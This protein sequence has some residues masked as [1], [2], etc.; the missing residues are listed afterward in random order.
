MDIRQSV[1]ETMRQN[2]YV[3]LCHRLT[4]CVCLA[5]DNLMRCYPDI[6]AECEFI[7]S[8]VYLESEASWNDA[9]NCQPIDEWEQ[10]QYWIVGK[11]IDNGAWEF[12]GLFS[13]RALA[14]KACRNKSYFIA[15]AT[16]DEAIVDTSEPWDGLVYPL[17]E[18]GI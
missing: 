11:Y 12:Q 10:A 4:K 18:E 9:Q 1:L 13:S 2:G 6:C 7:D 15:P 17:A 16:L 3:G 5:G 14:I 8:D